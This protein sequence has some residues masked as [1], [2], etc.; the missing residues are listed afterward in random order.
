MKK[1]ILWA[2]LAI[3]GSLCSCASNENVYSEVS[4][5]K[6]VPFHQEIPR[7]TFGKVEEDGLVIMH[8]KTNRIYRLQGEVG[9]P[10]RFADGD[11]VSDYRIKSAS[12]KDQKIVLEYAIKWSGKFQ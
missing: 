1:T 7:L 12:F 6:E 3:A 8:Y 9:Q 2:Y 5:S 11:E 4:Y 10:L